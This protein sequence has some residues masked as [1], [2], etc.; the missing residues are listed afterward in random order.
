MHILVHQH[1]VAAL[2]AEYVVVL[3]NAVFEFTVPPLESTP[4]LAAHV[5]KS[6]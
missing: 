5:T 6:G 3:D 4:G 2:G 1:D